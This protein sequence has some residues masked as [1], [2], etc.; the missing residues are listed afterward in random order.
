[1]KAY[2]WHLPPHVLEH[3]YLHLHALIHVYVCYTHKYHLCW[4]QRSSDA[5][6]TSSPAFLPFLTVILLLQFAL[7]LLLFRRSGHQGERAE[8]LSCHAFQSQPCQSLSWYFDY[9]LT[10]VC[11]T[12]IDSK[13]QCK[14]FPC[15]HLHNH[16]LTL[17]VAYSFPAKHDGKWIVRVG[18][19]IRT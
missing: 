17:Q 18:N 11:L 5:N 19:P 2:S 14:T 12:L 6:P 10:L 1:M 16:F 3:L 8:S 15:S 13:L 4:H 9:C 7:Y